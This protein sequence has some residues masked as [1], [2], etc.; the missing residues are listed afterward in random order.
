MKQGTEFEL[1]T[2]DLFSQLSKDREFESVQ[3]DVMLDGLDGKRQIDVL[4][5][6]KVGPF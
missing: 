5:T 3:H 2:T 4:L 6:G 1:L